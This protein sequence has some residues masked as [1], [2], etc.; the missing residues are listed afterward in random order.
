MGIALCL[1]IPLSDN[2]K[3]PKATIDCLGRFVPEVTYYVSSGTLNLAKLKL[4][5]FLVSHPQLQAEHQSLFF[6]WFSV[7]PYIKLFT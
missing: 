3:K 5:I 7:Y 1:K 2:E 4:I 6:D